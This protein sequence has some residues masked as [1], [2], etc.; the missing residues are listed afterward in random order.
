MRDVLSGRTCSNCALDCTCKKGTR[1]RV[2]MIMYNNGVE[3][4]RVSKLTE[5]V[6][7]KR[8]RDGKVATVRGCRN[9]KGEN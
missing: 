1:R 4:N 8:F 5:K 3:P 6:Q 2:R 9:L 7:R